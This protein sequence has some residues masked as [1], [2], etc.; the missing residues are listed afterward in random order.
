M[1]GIVVQGAPGLEVPPS[2]HFGG[3]LVHASPRLRRFVSDFIDGA[4]VSLS[5]DGLEAVLIDVRPGYAVFVL[6]EVVEPQRGRCFVVEL[7]ARPQAELRDLPPTV[8]RNTPVL[9]SDLYVGS[10]HLQVFNCGVALRPADSSR[11]TLR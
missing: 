2:K 7:V 4:L 3:H 1:T 8:R 5:R 10:A 11:Y 9:P 6:V